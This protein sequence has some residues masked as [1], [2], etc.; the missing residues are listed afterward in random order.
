MSD[1]DFGVSPVIGVVLLV[2]LVVILAGVVGIVFFDI[3]SQERNPGL[4]SGLVTDIEE[5][6]EGVEVSTLDSGSG[7][8]ILVDGEPVRNIS[9]NDTGETFVLDNI[10]EGSTVAIKPNESEDLTQ[11]ETVGK[12][13]SGGSGGDGGSSGLLS[14]D[15]ES[16]WV[17]SENT[18]ASSG[19]DIKSDIDDGYIEAVNGQGVYRGETVS[20]SEETVVEEVEFEYDASGA[21]NKRV[22]VTAFVNGPDMNRKALFREN[23]T[24]PIY[25]SG[26]GNKSFVPNSSEPITEITPY[27]LVQ[28]NQSN[29]TAAE[30]FSVNY[31]GNSDITKVVETKNIVLKT[32]QQ[33]S[34]GNFDVPGFSKTTISSVALP[35]TLKGPKVLDAWEYGESSY[36]Y[37]DI[38]SGGY[39]I[40]KDYVEN[41]ELK[42]SSDVDPSYTD[43]NIHNSDFLIEQA[44]DTIYLANNNK[45][46]GYKKDGQK[47]FSYDKNP[48]SETDIRWFH[49]DSSGVYYYQLD[50]GYM[51]GKKYYVRKVD[52]EGNIVWNKS[53]AISSNS[54]AVSDYIISN[55][56]VIDKTDGK[57]VYDKNGYR[58]PFAVDG[59][60]VYE[61]EYG[62]SESKVYKYTWDGS[63]LNKQWGIS[64]PLELNSIYLGTSAV[65]GLRSIGGQDYLTK[66][67][68][69]NGSV[70]W[71]VSNDYLG[72]LMSNGRFDLADIYYMRG[73]TLVRIDKSTGDI[74]NVSEY[75][76]EFN[77][78]ETGTIDNMILTQ[79]PLG[80]FDLTSYGNWINGSGGST[81]GYFSKDFS[82]NESIKV[83]NM[84]I[85][86]E[87]LHNSEYLTVLGIIENSDIPDYENLG[88]GGFSGGFIWRHPDNTTK[89]KEYYNVNRSGLSQNEN[90]N[91]DSG[92]NIRLLIKIEH[93]SSI[94]ESP[95]V[96]SINITGSQVS[97]REE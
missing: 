82:F 37:K 68:E 16:E 67:D 92:T 23:G 30:I 87:N 90:F 61:L 59:N 48:P 91:I 5:T 4:Q 27:L 55:G 80:R 13:Y 43:N 56:R 51:N 40:G 29:G 21:S 69:E 60:D 20:L 18:S 89:G 78:G 3:G 46:E 26:S 45:I 52:T 8:Q 63:N 34:Q 47:V 10:S 72:G 36:Q 70:E 57:V 44:G 54:K 49:A 9:E 15:T 2:A 94:M 73:D 62:T 64:H 97:Y 88:I 77:L 1:S 12:N 95:K 6:P 19:F 17:D 25:S 38:N 22:A 76:T 31:K 74:N 41:G 86:L 53:I 83:K 71:N 84:S 50:Y 58:V 81:A 24:T 42:W 79:A 65:Y 39:M 28:G 33:W 96:E 93:E 7:G 14:I 11:T 35:R 66:M 85:R 75:D 32:D